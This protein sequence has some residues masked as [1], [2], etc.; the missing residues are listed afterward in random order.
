MPFLTPLSKCPCVNK[1]D[2]MAERKREREGE[3]DRNRNA[4][5]E[6]RAQ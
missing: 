3:K 1:A 6:L 5:E 4:A 2:Q